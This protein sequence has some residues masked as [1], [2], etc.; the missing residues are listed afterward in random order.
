MDFECIEAG[1]DRDASRA[2]ECGA[3]RGDFLDGG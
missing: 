1:I 3:Q 2:G